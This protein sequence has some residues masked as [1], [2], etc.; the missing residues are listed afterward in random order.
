MAE[1]MFRSQRLSGVTAAILAGGLGTR[2]RPVVADR[3]KVLAP[4]AGRPFLAYLL[5]WL[6]AAGV[7]RT[8]LLT[9]F[10]GEQVRRR[11]GTATAKW[12][13]LIPKNRRRWGRA[14]PLAPPCVNSIRIGFCSSMEI[15]TAA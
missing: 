5:D 8:V 1:F 13:W 9:G 3:P 15:L 7:R 12:I 11:S 2:L 14:A 10:R 4:V 6:A